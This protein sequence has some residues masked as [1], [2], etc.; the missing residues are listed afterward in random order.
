MNKTV[1]ESTIQYDLCVSCGICEVVCP[2]KCISYNKTNGHFVPLINDS[3]CNRCGICS[4]ICSAH[5]EN[6]NKWYEMC[7]GK[8]RNSHFI[9]NFISCYNACS[10]EPH[11]RLNST[12]GG[13]ITTIVKALLDKGDYNCAFLVD[14]FNYE[15]FIKTK[16]FLKNDNLD[17]TSKSRY[18]PV[19]HGEMIE[20]AINNRNHKVII[21]ATSC[22]I[23][24]F[25]NVID[26]YKL[27]HNHYLLLG[28]F[29]DRT[30]SYNI[31]EYFKHY[32][33][34][35]K[36]LQYLYFRT[37]EKVGWPGNVKLEYTDQSLLYLQATERTKVKKYFQ[38]E[39]CLYCIDKLNIFSDISFGDNYTG[40]G[41]SKEGS[42]SIIVRSKL[43][44]EIFNSIKEK[45]TIEDIDI[46]EIEKSQKIEAR[47]TNL[48]YAK[49]LFREKGINIYPEIITCCN[50]VNII[51]IKSYRSM[52]DDINLG[53][54]YPNS[55][56]LL[57]RSLKKAKKRQKHKRVVNKIIRIIKG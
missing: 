34:N 41:S 56:P 20:Y 57:V 21:V 27:N 46:V 17:R 23:H 54:K 3:D 10:K 11:L 43:G 25:L 30:M 50:E 44:N 45:L 40:K 9:G 31:Y 4:E 42:N 14:D 48:E 1:L 39:R 37:K 6:Y 28:L 36:Q 19:S 18:I 49:I 52:K 8:K 2:K 24:T 15:E 12:S 22:V 7:G 35:N 16:V 53:N 26:K 32:N 55:K 47:K 29:C 33:N 38:L 5:F 13:C 51:D